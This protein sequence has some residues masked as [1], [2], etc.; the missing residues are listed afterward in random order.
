MQETVILYRT[1]ERALAARKAQARAGQPTL[2]VSPTT[3]AAYLAD[4]WDVWGDGRHLV[5]WQERLLLMHGS[6]ER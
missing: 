3:A 2:G 4:S 5:G 1:Y 6:I